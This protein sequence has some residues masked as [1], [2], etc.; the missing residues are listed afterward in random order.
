MELLQSKKNRSIYMNTF[1]NESL[2]DFSREDNKIKMRKA[3]EKV[4]H[5]CGKTYPLIINGE[6]IMTKE[7]IQS[8]NP[9]HLDDTIGFVAKASKN[10]AEKAIETAYNVF[11]KCAEWKKTSAET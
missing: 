10:E 8:I 6:K 9:S 4:V 3:L 11:T 1:K 7:K 5:E 2:T